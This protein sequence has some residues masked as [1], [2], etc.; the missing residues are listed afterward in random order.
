MTTYEPMNR[1]IL[2]I[3]DSPDVRRILGMRLQSA[4]FDVASEP[5]GGLGLLAAREHAPAL[6][7]VDVKMPKVDAFRFLSMLPRYALRPVPVFVMCEHDD[8]ALARRARQL[9][10][11]RFLTKG[12]VLHPGFARA[13]RDHCARHGANLFE[14]PF[15]FMPPSATRLAAA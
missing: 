5:D 12:Q 8:P 4:G 11:D 13:L 1:R 9:G 7:L 15:S 10:A 3:D 14:Y 2:I 6:I